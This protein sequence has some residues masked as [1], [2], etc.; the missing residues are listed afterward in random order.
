MTLVD[1]YNVG[2]IGVIKDLKPHT[3]PPEAWNIANNVRALDQ[4]MYS[5]GG[6]EEM[7]APLGD[8]PYFLFP[9]VADQVFWVWASLTDIYAWNGAAN[10]NISKAVGAYTAGEAR[11]WGGTILGGILIINNG[12]QP[13]QSWA[14]PDTAV[15]MTDL[16]NWPSSKRVRVLRAFGPHLVAVDV[17]QGATNHP[18]RVMWSHPAEPGSVPVSWDIDDPQVDSGE[19]DLPDIESG[20]LVDALPLRGQFFLY[21]E[22]SIWR[23]R[24]VGGRAKFAFDSF[25]V[26]TGAL[27]TRCVAATGDGK[28]HFVVTQNDVIV[29]NGQEER[30]VLDKR[31][32][33]S[34]FNMIDPNNYHSSFVFS[35]PHFNEM[36]LCYPSTGNAYPDRALIWNYRDGQV[37]EADCDFRSASVGPVEEPSTTTW[38]TVTGGWD[39]QQHPWSSVRKQQL[40]VASPSRSQILRLDSGLLDGGQP[41]ECTLLRE[42][43]SI[44]G[45][46][47]DGSP[48]VDFNKRKLV[49]RIWPIVEGGPISIRLGTQQ[50]SEGPV[51]W[52]AR[53]SFDPITQEY[54][55]FC[56][57][58]RAV[59]IEFYSKAEVA[60]RLSSY[61]LDMEIVGE[62]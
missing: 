27:A 2:G 50:T 1:I 16:P 52:T 47:R 6:K 21:K 28:F 3:L 56:I 37:T 45:K 42:G 46:R 8:T 41:V 61:K 13:P 10:V 23:M 11:N 20:K 25:L 54:L 39:E 49:T 22:A 51:T 31:M 18:H 59:A 4:E 26:T 55:D 58:G 15:R 44:V 7:F 38:D 9:I 5:I 33:R 14:N 62:Y 12:Q 19:Y 34:L 43:L 48:V 17:T 57:E 53:Q 32:R 36:W 24:Y 40:L 30:S 35:H 29:H 60:W